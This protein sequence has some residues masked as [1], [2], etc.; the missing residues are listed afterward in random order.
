M[1][2]LS[3]KPNWKINYIIFETNIITTLKKS[4]DV[5][6]TLIAKKF[7][8]EINSHVKRCLEKQP[9]NKRPNVFVNEIFEIFLSK[10]PLE[11]GNV[12]QK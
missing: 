12:Q 7:D 6:H 5:E 1:S 9:A 11:K 2:L 8:E 3:K 10:D 4:V